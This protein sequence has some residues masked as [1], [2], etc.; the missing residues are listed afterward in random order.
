M[1]AACI[2]AIFKKKN[3]Y[4]KNKNIRK[5][6]V[7]TTIPDTDTGFVQKLFFASIQVLHIG[8]SDRNI[9]GKLLLPCAREMSLAE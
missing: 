7:K 6:K 2:I 1:V 8:C 3:T 9:K 4:C 5:L